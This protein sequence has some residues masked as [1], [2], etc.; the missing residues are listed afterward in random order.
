MALAGV[1]PVFAHPGHDAAA[2][3][4]HQHPETMIVAAVAVALLIGLGLPAL[5]RRLARRRKGS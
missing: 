2:G 3:V 5:R 4:F 1:T